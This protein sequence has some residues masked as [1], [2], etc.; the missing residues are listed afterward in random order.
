MCSL[1]GEKYVVFRLGG[2]FGF[3]EHIQ[4]TMEQCIEARGENTMYRIAIVEDRSSDAQRLQAALQQY[5]EEKRIGFVC[6]R[7]NSAENFLEQYNHQFDMVFMD[8]RLPGMDGMQAARELRK[9]DHTVLLVF[10]TSLA[11]YA[12]EG[13][14]VEAVDYI[15]KPI[16]YPALRLKM[17][18][19]LRRCATD[20][21][22][23][24]I[25][26]VDQSVKLRPRDLLYVE[27][28]DHHIQYMTQNGVIRA[29]GTL[30]EIEDTLPEGF[31]RVNNQTIINL[32]H[33]TCVNG[34]N[35]VLGGREFPL[36]R[37]RRKSFLE[38]LHD[39]G[40]QV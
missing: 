26:S 30:K 39:S 14:E 33:V 34:E 13:Y 3:C 31:F 6:K 7:W 5:A 16:T 18:R 11:Q 15:I 32:K 24:I 36:S 40:I 4:K 1:S 20:E 35:V 2:S 38:A 17:P 12:V 23:I 8:I 9:I 37:R 10:L 29:Y 25:E 22:E 27:I 21:E 28:F 19:L